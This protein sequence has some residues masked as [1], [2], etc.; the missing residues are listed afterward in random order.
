MDS[1]ITQKPHAICVPYPAQSHIKGMLKLAK[2]LHSRGIQITFVNTEYNHNRFL[3]SGGLDSLAGLPDFQFEAIPDCLPPSDS[4]STQ[5]LIDLSES[6]Q[7]NCLVPFLGLLEKIP[8][9]TCIV[10]D[11]FVPFTIDAGEKVGIPVV[12]FWTIAACNFIRYFHFDD[13][14]EKGK[15]I[16]LKDYPSIIKSTDPEDIMF[17]YSVESAMRCTKASAN[18][19]STFDDL[20]AD[21]VSILSA[22][23]PQ[24]YTVGP[25]QLLLNLVPKEEHLTSIGYNLWK[26]ESLCLEWLDS[27][28][29]SSVLYVNFGSIA[30]M[31]SKKVVEFALGLANSGQD[32]LWIIRPDLV[33]GESAILPL[34]FQEVTKERGFI[35]SWCPQEQVLS[36]RS[37]GGFLTHCGWNSTIESLSAGVPMIC[38]PFFGDQ[39][40]NCRYVCTEWEVGL[41]I[42]SDINR[43]DVEKVVKELMEGEKG[44]KMKNK[45]LEWKKKA[46]KATGAHGSS[47]L[48]LDMLVNKFFSQ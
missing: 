37:V 30:V 40:T 47:S 13:L 22:M 15:G 24:V 9:A 23:I 21:N 27:R 43:D 39:P 44:K 10:S 45:A 26:E 28:E 35:A 36:H 46:D 25:L 18:I 2:L 19:I 38:L 11:G 41:E 8:P 3:K 17:K 48:N 29:S 14:R 31:S 1:V 33:M 4:D 12:L 32:F 7:N 20:E 6:L 42:D 5:N 34:E 16:R